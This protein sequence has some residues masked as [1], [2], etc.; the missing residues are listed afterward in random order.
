[1]GLNEPLVSPLFKFTSGTA[2]Y[3]TKESEK[4][5]KVKF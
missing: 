5:D 2:K 4:T 1:M 3:C